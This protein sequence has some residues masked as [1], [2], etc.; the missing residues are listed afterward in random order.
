MFGC[1]LS[2]RQYCRVGAVVGGG[3]DK[4][5]NGRWGRAERCLTQLL[6]YADT[7]VID[8][9]AECHFDPVYS[10]EG[11]LTGG[12]E[13][14]G[15]SEL[16]PVHGWLWPMSSMTVYQVWFSSFNGVRGVRWLTDRQ[17]DS[18]TDKQ[19]D[20][21]MQYTDTQIVLFVSTFRLIII[22]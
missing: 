16:R 19:T 20:R 3:G 8:L 13:W 10:H 22:T 5:R 12:D 2:N 18:W 6:T 17:T 1:N 11:G 4:C 9:H 7:G 15:V 14:S 21:V